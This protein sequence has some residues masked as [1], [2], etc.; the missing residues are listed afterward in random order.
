MAALC[1]LKTNYEISIQYYKFNFSVE[2]F[3]VA[4]WIIRSHFYV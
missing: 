4:T 1:F 2:C 3:L